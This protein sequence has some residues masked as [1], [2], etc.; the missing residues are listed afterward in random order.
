[1]FSSTAIP[2]GSFV[3]EYEGAVISHDKAVSRMEMNCGTKSHNYVIIFKENYSCD[4]D[5]LTNR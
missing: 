4:D 1:M 5:K 2:K 3:C